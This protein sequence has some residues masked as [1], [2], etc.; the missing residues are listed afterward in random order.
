MRI[1]AHPVFM[2]LSAF[3]TS[4]SEPAARRRELVA[5]GVSPGH[6]I[7]QIPS[8]DRA[9][10]LVGMLVGLFFMP[11]RVTDGKD[12]VTEA[13]GNATVLE[14]ELDDLDPGLTPFAT[15]FGPDGAVFG[16]GCLRT[17]PGRQA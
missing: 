5:K 8:G 9:L 2:R 14:S 1:Q 16:F 6:R 10:A 15:G 11:L 4:K 13:G 17:E 3:R 12:A 7:I